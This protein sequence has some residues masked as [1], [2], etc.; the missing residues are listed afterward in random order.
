MFLADRAQGQSRLEGFKTASSRCVRVAC[1]RAPSARACARPM[2]W[3]CDEFVRCE[4][5]ESSTPRAVPLRA[6][7]A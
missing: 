2:T 4:F 1:L 7:A 3:T 5:I 6:L